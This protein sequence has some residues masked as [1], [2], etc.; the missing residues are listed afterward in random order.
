LPQPSVFPV[1]SH[2]DDRGKLSFCNDLDFFQFKRFYIISPKSVGQVRA[3]QAHLLEEKVF[4]PL[5]GKIK[6]VVVPI[7]DIESDHFGD[8]KEF[9]LDAKTPELI[10]LPGGFV[11]GFQFLDSDAELMIFSNF[12]LE[13]S[14]FYFW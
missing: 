8:P 11:N 14:R 9:I 1:K 3:W 12:S 2:S 10:H 6:I 4:L 7:V 13:E 5:K